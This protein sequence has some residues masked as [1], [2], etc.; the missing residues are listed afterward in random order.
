MDPPADQPPLP[1]DPDQLR[2]ELLEALREIARL[3]ELPRPR[4]ADDLLLLFGRIAG[5]MLLAIVVMSAFI[6]WFRPETDISD[7]ATVINTQLSL[8]IGAVLG[9][10]AHPAESKRS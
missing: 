1:E 2:A 5:V 10:A 7:L 4:V 6:V 9:W 3:K 8:V